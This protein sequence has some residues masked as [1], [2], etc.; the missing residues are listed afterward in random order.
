MGG[1]GRRAV[2]AVRIGVIGTGAMGAAHV[3]MLHQWIPQAQVVAA[4]DADRPRAEQVC[5]EVGARVEAGP[6]AV[7]EASDVDAVLIAAPDALHE[8]LVLACLAAGRPTLCEKPLATS[9]DGSRAVMAAEVRGGRRLI[10]IGFMRR[11][12]P[13]YVDLR[14]LVTDRSLG[15]VRVVHCVHRNPSAHPTA[16]SEGIIRNS[17]VHELDVVPWLLDDRWASVTVRVP[18]STANGLRDPQVAVLETEGGVVVTTEVFVNAR[19]GYDVRC[20]VVGDVG[21]ARLIPPSGLGIRRDQRDELAVAPGFVDRFEDAYRL[22][23]SAWVA[24]A[25]SG[26]ATGAS[27]WDAYRADVAAE[28]ACRSL[29]TGAREPITTPEA[30]ALYRD[31]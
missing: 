2:R 26:T 28:A 6:D 11:Y 5:G 27:A 1:A 19:Y 9:A 17:M 23:L 3:R 13:A 4:Y 25:A 22:E 10:Q 20:E 24:A 8:E 31:S 29:A 12:D 16:T 30:P 21:T 18:R 14:D 7:I 15:A